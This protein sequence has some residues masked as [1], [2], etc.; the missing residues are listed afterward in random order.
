[1]LK[2]IKKWLKCR[3]LENGISKETKSGTPQGGVI[4]P[5]LANIYLHEFDKFWVER[6]K[7]NGKLVRYADDIVILFKTKKEAELGLKI[8]KAM[9]EHLRLEL[10]QDKT[11][12][13]DTKNG[14][15]GFDFLGF[16]HRMVKSWK[17]KKRYSQKWP[18]NKAMNSI[19]GN[20]KS[21]LKPRSILNWHLDDVVKKLNPILRGWMNYFRFGNSSRKFSHIDD[22]LHE[23]L[24]LWWN[25]K[26]QKS[27]RG[28]KSNFTYGEFKICR[29]LRL[30]GN[31]VKWSN[32]LNAKERR[33]SESRVRENFM[34]GLMRGS[35]G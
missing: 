15:D 1:M 7:I 35:W 22:Y 16:H 28:W 30:C 12:I 17:Y 23:R 29:V 2:L 3:V 5:L 14:K 19:R 10:N 27:G 21:I 13:V 25:K 33:S 8:V 20:I 26:H 6:N 32:F 24:A 18:S 11:K 4:S 31:V 9:L 34:H